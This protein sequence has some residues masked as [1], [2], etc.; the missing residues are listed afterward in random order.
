LIA[1][2]LGFI[3]A[4]LAHRCL[5]WAPMSRLRQPRPACGGTLYNIHDIRDSSA[6]F[7]DILNFDASSSTY[8]RDIV[9]NC[10]ASTCPVVD[11]RLWFD[12]GAKQRRWVLRRSDASTSGPPWCIGTGTQLGP[13]STAGG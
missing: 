6:P 5:G 10:A 8:Q 4:N 12:L 1:G 2:E 13:L 9:F 11:A 7:G 3:G